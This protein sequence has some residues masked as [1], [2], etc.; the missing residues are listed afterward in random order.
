[1]MAVHLYGMLVAVAIAAFVIV[2]I[3]QRV[4]RALA[5]RDEE[6]ARERRL[7]EQRAKLA[8]LGT[9]AAGA[10]HE[11]ATPLG[12]IAVAVQ[13][14]RPR[15]LPGRGRAGCAR[16]PP[17]HPRRRWIAARASFSRCRP[18]PARTPASPS[19]RS[20]WS[21]GWRARSTGCPGGIGSG[22]DLRCGEVRV[23]GPVQGME[24][25]LR[26]ILEN[27]LQA[28]HRGR[29]VALRALLRRR[30][31]APSRCRIGGAGMSPGGAGARRGAVLHHQG[32]GPG[33]RPG[34]LHRADAGR[35]AGRRARRPRRSRGRDHGADRP[36]GHAAGARGGTRMSQERGQG[37]GADAPPRGRR[38]GA[39][40]AAGRRRCASAGSR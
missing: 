9:L 18:A 4:T 11:L 38:R 13:G 37:R 40:G 25:A 27:A 2:L 12:A 28:L 16:R 14:A 31:H 21:A 32:S 17:A 39:A 3:V 8:S 6:L 34:A 1:M 22:A 30:G 29:G 19:W 5:V 36:S 23:R 33:K 10:A 15:A 24:R 26:V 7:A 35:A 20:R